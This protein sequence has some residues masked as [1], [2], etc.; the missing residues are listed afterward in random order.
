MVPT[1]RKIL[2]SRTFPGP[3]Y[4]FP[5]QRIQDLKVINKDMC[6]KEYHIYSMLSDIDFLH[7][8]GTSSSPLLTV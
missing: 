8:Y 1:T 2:F 5:G 4:H 7:F 3:N 6:E